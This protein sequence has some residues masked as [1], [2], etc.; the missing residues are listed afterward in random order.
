[1]KS[2]STA[3]IA[4]LTTTLVILGAASLNAESPKDRQKKA[5]L[6]IVAK[7]FEPQVIDTHK[8]VEHVDVSDDITARVVPVEKDGVWAVDVVM[9]RGEGGRGVATAKVRL[10]CTVETMSVMSRVSRPVAVEVGHEDLM[11]RLQPGQTETRR[12]VFRPKRGQG[13]LAGGTARITA[14]VGQEVMAESVY[15]ALNGMA[16]GP[17]LNDLVRPF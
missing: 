14:S 5:M 13:K 17:Q 3:V 9:R 7:H 11:V 6:D 16:T 4:F 1:M 2:R 12:V 10:N 8:P 15:V